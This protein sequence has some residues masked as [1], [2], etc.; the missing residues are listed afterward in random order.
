MNRP[1]VAVFR[2]LVHHLAEDRDDL[3]GNGRI[4]DARV[5]RLEMLMMVQLLGR[6][7]LRRRRLAGQHVIE[8]AAQG[9]DVAAGVGL[10][11]L[12]RLLGRNVVEG[13]QRHARLRQVGIAA[14]L[15]IARQPHIDELRPAIRRD[16]DVRRL[17]IAMHDAA[18]VGVFQT[19]GDLKDIANRFADRNSAAAL[20]H[21]PQVDAF[22]ELERDE[23]Q[24]LVFAAEEDA[25]DIF[26]I[27]LRGGLGLLMKPLHV[28]GLLGHLRR[29]DFQGDEAIQLRIVG[30]D[31]RRH[32]ADADR[33]DQLVMGQTPSV[34]AGDD[35]FG[36]GRPAG[37]FGDLVFV[38]G[39]RLDD[40]RR[41]G[42]DGRAVVSRARSFRDDQ[43][44]LIGNEPETRIRVFPARCSTCNPLPRVNYA[45][46]N[47]ANASRDRIHHA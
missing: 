45:N 20:E 21:G 4:D 9:I 43:R 16:D 23:V 31:D 3:V 36:T 12:Q 33:L 22:D 6:R 15:Q 41:L 11:R 10:A 14:P 19:R 40:G 38:A 28:I 13:P 24:P 35:R 25:G 18:R 1:L 44:F 2:V 47:H 46:R 34:Q 37:E 5:E 32:A 42:D 8:R 39:N 26:V 7:P 29:Q 27:E 30:P 17:D